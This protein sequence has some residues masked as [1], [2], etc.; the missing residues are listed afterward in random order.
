MIIGFVHHGRPPRRYT[1]CLLKDSLLRKDH[2]PYWVKQL[3]LKFQKFYAN[4][5]LRPQLESLGKG[6]FI[7]KP[8]NV[9][10]F[11]A[12]VHIGDYV[13]I[14]GA[15][16]RRIR[17]SVWPESPGKGGIR[18]GNYCLI[19][20]GVRISS[21]CEITIQESCMIASNAYITDSD[22]HDIYNRISIG[23]SAPIVLEKNV[24]IGD[25]AIICKGVTIGQ[26]SIIGAGSV[27]V[28]AVPENT[29]AAGNPARVVK[30]LDP[31][32]MFKTRA[33]WYA[34]PGRLFAQLDLWDRAMLRGNTIPGWIRSILFPAKGD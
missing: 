15:P 29:I 27:V 22:W 1:V 10:I 4:R 32:K 5:F 21:A 14:I 18:I 33:Q 6:F 34:D 31:G 12:P 11:G 8:W 19:C 25:S 13:M 9:E 26:N 23:K 24:W 3:Y 7:I 20:P 16:D 2:R 17:F 28:N 30:S